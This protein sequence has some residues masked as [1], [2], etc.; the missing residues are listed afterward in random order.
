MQ[1][2]HRHVNR[3]VGCAA[4]AGGESLRAVPLGVVG[5][6]HPPIGTATLRIVAPADATVVPDVRQ[7][8]RLR[9][10]NIHELLRH[11]RL[12]E[13]GS[14]RSPVLL[15]KLGHFDHMLDVKHQQ[16]VCDLVDFHQLCS[17]KKQAPRQRP[18]QST[19]CLP[20][21]EGVL[22]ELGRVVYFNSYFLPAPGR[23]LALCAVVLERGQGHSDRLLL[24]SPPRA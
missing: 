1:H 8:D 18:R 20:S 7:D 10:C 11:T 24:V 14:P 17:Q 3:L 16:R 5:A 12:A 22:P 19:A 6:H 13:H 21:G 9:H 23:L 2:G 4:W 15:S